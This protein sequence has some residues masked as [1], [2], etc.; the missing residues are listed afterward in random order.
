MLSL[1]FGMKTY[2]MNIKAATHYVK[3]LIRKDNTY[4]MRAMTFNFRITVL[5]SKPVT[6]HQIG[7]INIKTLVESKAMNVYTWNEHWY[8]KH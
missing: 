7:N 4:L 8:R 2:F 5:L 3:Q 1:I 6:K